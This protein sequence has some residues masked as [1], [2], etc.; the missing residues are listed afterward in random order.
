[1][2]RH[3]K[4]S[5]FALSFIF[6]S[7]Q[8]LPAELAKP[9][10]SESISSIDTS[11]IIN[12]NTSKKSISNKYADSASVSVYQKILRPSLYSRC[13]YMP[14][15][16]AYA[17][18]LA[19]NCGTAVSLLKTFDRFLREPDA[20]YFKLPVVSHLHGLS[21]VDLPTNCEL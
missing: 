17:Q 10:R 9:H 7:C 18:T 11:Y 20:G 21:F 19:R 13:Q 12:K 6:A 15:D 2:F 3:L 5:F 8:Q 1:M 4:N 14:S 16:S